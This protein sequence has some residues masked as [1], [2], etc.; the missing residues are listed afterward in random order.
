MK[1]LDN[2][3]IHAISPR[4]RKFELRLLYVKN[5]VIFWTVWI[6]L[7]QCTCH[8]LCNPQCREIFLCRRTEIFFV[9]GSTTF[10]LQNRV[11]QMEGFVNIFSYHSIAMQPRYTWILHERHFGLDVVNICGMRSVGANTIFPI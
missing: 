10:Y 9:I 2:D 4:L 3:S 8:F 5:V 1:F 7:W 6:I 11:Q